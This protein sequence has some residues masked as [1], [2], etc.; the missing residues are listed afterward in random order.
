VF[1]VCAFFLLKCLIDI[2]KNGAVRPTVQEF[3]VVGL[4]VDFLGVGDMASLLCDCMV[5]G[6]VGRVD[7]VLGVEDAVVDVKVI[8]VS[9][10]H[11]V[12]RLVLVPWDEIEV[13]ASR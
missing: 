12:D 5:K 9:V 4:N 6:P 1:D 10:E 13:A 3:L 2:D 8:I 7:A 11:D